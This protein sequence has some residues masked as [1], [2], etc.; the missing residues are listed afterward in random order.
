MAKPSDAETDVRRRVFD[1]PDVI[2]WREQRPLTIQETRGILG[3]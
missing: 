1:A 3:R 2:D